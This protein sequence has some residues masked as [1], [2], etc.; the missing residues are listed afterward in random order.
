MR[1]TQQKIMQL[2]G[3][4]GTRDISEWEEGFITNI[5]RLRSTHGDSVTTV[6][7]EKQ[8]GTIEDIFKKHFEG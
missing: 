6:L 3:L 4:L 5:V 2:E 7:S 8:L 1:S